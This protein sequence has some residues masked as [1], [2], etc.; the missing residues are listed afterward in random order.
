MV[1]SDAEEMGFAARKGLI[2]DAQRLLRK[3]VTLDASVHTGA[4]AYLAI[5]GTKAVAFFPH[6]P[7]SAKPQHCDVFLHSFRTG[8]LENL[9]P[10]RKTPPQAS[11]WRA[12][13]KGGVQREGLDRRCH[14]IAASLDKPEPND[15]DRIG[16]GM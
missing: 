1:R 6:Y 11:Q 2:Y 5:I 8:L 4:R 16:P 10:F 13:R 3:T 7:N 14:P 12:S 15:G 9:L